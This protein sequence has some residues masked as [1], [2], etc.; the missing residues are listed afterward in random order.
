MSPIL[1]W[2]LLILTCGYALTR[3]RK[4]ERIVAG[5]C[6]IASVVTAFVL[7]SWRHRYTGVETGELLVDVGTLAAFVFVALR[8]D[9]FWPL[10]VAGLQLTTSMSHM[11]K[12]VDL[13]LGPQA[14]AAAEKFWSYPILLILAAGTWRGHRR[15]LAQRRE[16][17]AT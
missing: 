8:S 14:Y 15:M 6:V 4:D 2:T 17:A 16:S 10:W 5:V 13:G 7:S 3:G 12:A 11:L 9:R 1:Y